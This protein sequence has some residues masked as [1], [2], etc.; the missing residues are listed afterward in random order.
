MRQNL[1]KRTPPR[2]EPSP[3]P[4]AP[5]DPSPVP[6]EPAPAVRQESRQGPQTQVPVQVG[7]TPPK[8]AATPVPTL[9]RAEPSPSPLG[10]QQQQQQQ[11]PS[12]QGQ[13]P[14]A[15]KRQSSRRPKSTHGRREQRWDEEEVVVALDESVSV[16]PQPQGPPAARAA[17][18]PSFKERMKARSRGLANEGVSNT[19][20][21]NPR[22]AI[23]G[24]DGAG[25]GM[26]MLSRND[27]PREVVKT[28]E[29][30]GMLAPNPRPKG[31]AGH[32]PVHPSAGGT[33]A[34][35]SNAMLPSS[36]AAQALTSG[37]ELP[38]ENPP[39]ESHT[40]YIPLDQVLGDDL[41][42]IQALT[43]PELHVQIPQGA[44][45]SASPYPAR[46]P[47]PPKK[48]VSSDEYTAIVEMNVSYGSTLTQVMT[49]IQGTQ[50]ALEQEARELVEF[51]RHHGQLVKESVLLQERQAIL[52]GI[53]SSSPRG[54]TPTLS[55]MPDLNV[56]P[57]DAALAEL[58]KISAKA[59]NETR[60]NNKLEARVMALSKQCKEKEVIPEKLR[61]LRQAFALQKAKME[62]LLQNNTMI[63]DVRQQAAEQEKMVG[64]QIPP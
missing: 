35:A 24:N 61:A 20:S 53:V 52:D 25:D 39:L 64:W 38:V 17:A 28:E 10:Q 43:A 36:H 16:Q 33:G 27:R 49:E 46:S 14:G 30:G 11:Q 19:A 60:N 4:A 31:P 57:D 12:Q 56:Y 3:P 26:G 29:L 21:S 54:A 48:I 55:E 51:R 40:Q 23:S 44:L 34:S 63:E 15:D 37:P 41:M 5:S 7:A 62:L 2:S 1:A 32:S 58:N 45:S 50:A 59:V 42:D 22:A 8:A 6:L 47:A 9:P 13:D 18:Q